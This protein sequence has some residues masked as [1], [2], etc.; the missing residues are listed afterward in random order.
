LEYT[1]FD[2]LEVIEKTCEIMAL[3]P[4]QNNVELICH[5]RPD[6][7]L[8]LKGDP[9]R[10]QQILN[11]LLGNAVKFTHEGEIFLQVKA[12]ESSSDKVALLFSVT[13]TGIGIP[14]EKKRNIFEPYSQADVIV[15]REYGG[16]GLGLNICKSLVEMMEGEIRVESEP[17]KGS[18][19]FFTARLD[20]DPDPAVKTHRVPQRIKG[21][22]V[23]VVDD[24]AAHRLILRETLSSWGAI[25]AE[26]EGGREGLEV[27]AKAEKTGMPFRLLLIDQ[28]MPEMNGFEM[29]KQ[30]KDH[31]GHSKHAIMLLSS[32]ESSEGISRAKELGMSAYDK[33]KNAEYDLVLMDIQM[34][35]MDG[36]AVVSEKKW[37]C[38]IL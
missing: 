23:L 38:M 5:V 32:H 1:G 16:T 8:Y 36:Y 10:L 9:M 26:A 17:G 6:T 3:K 25:V 29:A 12:L 33:F 24:N 35:V 7:P 20:I 13:D 31:S 14:K 19:F 11:N 34:P 4:H 27:I 2:L 28:R 37:D 18:T 15:S 21:H 30:I 22:R